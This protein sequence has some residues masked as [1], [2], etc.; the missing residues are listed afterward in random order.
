ML[1]GSLNSYRRYSKILE[2]KNSDVN[3]NI[4]ILDKNKESIIKEFINDVIDYYISI[5][6][7][8]IVEQNIIRSLYFI[9]YKKNKIYNNVITYIDDNICNVNLLKNSIYH[10]LAEETLLD[11]DNFIK[12]YDELKPLRK[13]F[14]SKYSV[15]K[16][17][18]SIA[19]PDFLKSLK[20]MI[21]IE[22]DK[23]IN[24]NIYNILL[25]KK[26]EIDEIKFKT[27]SSAV[28]YLFTKQLNN[29]NF[30]KLLKSC[31]LVEEYKYE[32]S[33]KSKSSFKIDT[34]ISKFENMDINYVYNNIDLKF[35]DLNEDEI[36]KKLK[37]F[38]I[39]NT[40][41]KNIPYLYSQN[42]KNK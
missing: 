8:I 5:F 30:E 14:K 40:Y 25:D 7:D 15:L 18:I 26:E 36:I 34:V 3:D 1:I 20:S 42:L 6:P 10:L 17:Y 21:A 38:Y 2:D 13:K 9:F 23:N 37:T 24:E 4:N 28:T 31:S 33:G 11:F 27:K 41:I 35:K 12:I 39:K 32:Y 16:E 29:K 19:S 22:I